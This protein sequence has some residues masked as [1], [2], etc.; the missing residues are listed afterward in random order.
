MTDD[1]LESPTVNRYSLRKRLKMPI[2]RKAL[3]LKQDDIFLDIGCGA[4]YF[5]AELSKK[6]KKVYGLDYS[7]TNIEAVK[8]RYGYIKNIDFV[9]GDATNMP[10]KNNSFDVI[11]ATEIIEHI[12]DDNKFVKECHRVLKKN[13]RLI[14]TTPCT[15]PTISVDWF[16][17]L[18]GI[19][20]RSDFGHKRP[21]YTKKQL[22]QILK[23]QKLEPAHVEYYDQI[24]GEVAWVFT[25]M[26]RALTNKNWSSGE[27]Q[28]KIDRSFL[29]KIYKLVFP[30]IFGF[31]KLDKLIKNFKGHHVLVKSIKP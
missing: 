8:K 7:K 6:V 2:L 9:L 13:G 11:L 27:G 1:C 20:M 15:N 31:A 16:R 12:Q 3:K 18:G 30:F 5:S 26:P 4:G 22:F 17:R 10:F 25:C 29:F 19:N 14:I 24:F 23:S 21:G 28:D